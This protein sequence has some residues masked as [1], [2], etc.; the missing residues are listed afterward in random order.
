MNREFKD[1]S[2][3]T[4]SETKMIANLNMDMCLFL[5]MERLVVNVSNQK[6]LSIQ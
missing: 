4:S 5:I 1:T 2:V 6:Q 3:L